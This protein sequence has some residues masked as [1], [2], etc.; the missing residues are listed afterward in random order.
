LLH[1]FELGARWSA[2]AEEEVGMNILYGVW[3]L[4]PGTDDASKL[5]FLIV[6]AGGLGVAWGL[7]RWL[8]KEDLGTTTKTILKTQRTADERAADERRELRELVLQLSV[9]VDARLAELSPPSPD[10]GMGHAAAD[11]IMK[12]LT[13]AVHRLAAQDREPI[14]GQLTAGAG[15]A[16]MT[17][18]AQMRAGLSKTRVA[19]AKEEARL[20]R[21]QGALA[22]LD[23]THEA[24]RHYK[25]ACE[26][27]PDDEQCWNGLGALQFAAGD[28]DGARRCFGRVMELEIDS[29]GQEAF[30]YAACNLGKIHFMQG[31]L[32]AAE[33]L[34]EQA[35]ALFT[36]VEHK[37]G[38]AAS[39]GMLGK[40]AD[41][42]Q[43]KA[44]A[45]GL[46]ANALDLFR[47]IGMKPQIEEVETWMREAGCGRI[48]RR[49]PVFKKGT[50]VR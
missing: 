23:D 24:I 45:C 11:I 26:L 29:V 34:Q 33:A 30:A 13:S 19:A 5:R 36:A 47:Q 12:D 3:A 37:A 46:W 17:V 7:V 50:Q 41:R 2:A 49:M 31:G 1:Q 8:R 6:A 39:Y 15:R 27:D 22:F 35:L 38:M 44:G 10:P 4:F 48:E 20:A 32:E 42:R 16:A 28:L 9:R 40:V 25:E 21:E 14:I 43:D 18:L